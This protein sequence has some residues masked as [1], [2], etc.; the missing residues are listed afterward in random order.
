MS[1]HA[2]TPA[3]PSTRSQRDRSRSRSRRRSS[4]SPSRRRRSTHDSERSRRRRSPSKSDSSSGSSRSRSPRA[5]PSRKAPEGF[6][7]SKASPYQ[8]SPADGRSYP[9]FDPRDQA[10]EDRTLSALNTRG[11]LEPRVPLVRGSL[12]LEGV[13]FARY[14]GMKVDPER[15]RAFTSAI[16]DDLISEAGN[17]VVRED[18]LL[19]LTPGPI[20]TVVLDYA[21]GVTKDGLLNLPSLVDAEWCI[22]CEYAI[23]ARNE[24]RQV[25]IARTLFEALSD[26]DL[27]MDSTRRAYLKYLNS[28]HADPNKIRVVPT[29]TA[30]DAEKKPQSPHHRSGLYEEADPLE[31]R[32]TWHERRSR[33]DL[34]TVRNLPDAPN[35]P[36]ARPHIV[37]DVPAIGGV[38][39]EHRPKPDPAAIT[40]PQS[41]ARRTQQ[42]W[43]DTSPS[44]EL[45]RAMARES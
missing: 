40:S 37:G 41:Y 39:L 25:A 31:G 33:Q 29:A 6:V 9:S 3:S 38:P 20:K 16:R 45:K 34:P 22:D 13:N 32:Y 10:P 14:E 1:S 18:I 27:A 36:R 21:S 24:D 11:P 15:Q 35:S 44:W 8:G 26:G 7:Y 17:G 28:N 4:S 19:R 23:A 2:K 42:P 12:R 43:W 5:T 30:E